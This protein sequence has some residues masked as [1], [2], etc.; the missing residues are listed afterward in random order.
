MKIKLFT[1]GGSRGNPG[2]SACAFY[3]ESEKGEVVKGHHLGIMTNNQA[4]Y[5]GLIKGLMYIFKAMG[6]DN[7][8]EIFMDSQ[9]IV[10]QIKGTYKVKN[11][12]LKKLNELAKILLE[13]F[14]EYTIEHIRRELNTKADAEL[15]RI[16][17]ENK[18]GED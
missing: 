18:Q 1:D 16:L 2:E 7:R 17:D 12:E 13:Q 6:G 8:I 11:A 10:N 15:N 4:E 5:M 9:L 3:I 14:S